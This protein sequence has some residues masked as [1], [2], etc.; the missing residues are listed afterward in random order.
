M[1]IVIKKTEN[2]IEN[3]QGTSIFGTN[4]VYEKIERCMFQNAHPRYGWMFEESRSLR[5]LYGKGRY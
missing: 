4:L 5:C 3:V 2:W 1:E